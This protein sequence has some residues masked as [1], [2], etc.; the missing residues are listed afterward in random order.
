MAETRI[1]WERKTKLGSNG[2][3]GYVGK[4]R[5]FSVHWSLV[6]KGDKPWEVRTQ[7]PVTIR[8]DHFAEE[9]EAQVY[10]ESVLA[11]FVRSIGATFADGS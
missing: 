2:W 8:G 4:H 1:R 10:A 6:S 7:L 11:G 9:G 3:D 5:L